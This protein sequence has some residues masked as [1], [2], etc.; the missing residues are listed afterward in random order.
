M[1][2]SNDPQFTSKSNLGYL[3][4]LG[5]ETS[6]SL[7]THHECGFRKSEISIFLEVNKP[8][9]CPKER[10]TCVSVTSE[11][12]SDSDCE[13]YLK[14]CSFNCE[15]KCMDS[16]QEPCFLKLDPGNC[17]LTELRWHFDFNRKVCKP[18]IYKGC[19]KN[20]NNFINW[21]D[22]QKACSSVVK[23]G[24]C[25]HFPF[26]NRMECT[27]SC[28]SDIDC[29]ENEKCCESICGFSCSFAR[30]GTFLRSSYLHITVEYVHH[31]HR[32]KGKRSN[33]K[34]S[35]F[36]VPKTAQKYKTMTKYYQVKCLLL[37]YI[38]K[39]GFCPYKPSRCPVIEKPKCLHDEDCPLS[40]K[41]CSVCG[42]KCRQPAK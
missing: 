27:S 7:D 9:I 17:R 21:E 2:T 4:K 40:F 20:S 28:K 35:L 37:P 36:R 42:L 39:E 31:T 12:D 30:I 11:C 13:G 19:S 38:G 29:P 24:Q 6:A 26:K 14:C 3:E 23:K 15:R 41:C 22:C 32:R 18:F 5:K 33:Q 1:V 10:F 34:R 8:G 25:P 16:Y